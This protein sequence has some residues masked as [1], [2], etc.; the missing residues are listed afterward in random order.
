MQN[1]RWRT[2]DGGW[3]TSNRRQRMGYGGQ[4]IVDGKGR[5]WRTENDKWRTEDGNGEWSME[6]KE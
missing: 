6:D 2:K 1:G 4:R 3:G 5:T